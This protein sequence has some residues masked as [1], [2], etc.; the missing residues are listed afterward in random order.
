MIAA[1]LAMFLIALLGSRA[2]AVT[3]ATT[4][5]QWGSANQSRQSAYARLY[6]RE[7]RSVPGGGNSPA[8]V[9]DAINNG[10]LRAY[11]DDV[12]A[13]VSVLQAISGNF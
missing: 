12:S 8:S 13:T 10:C 1:L 6:L 9:L 7:H 4:C 5:S 2:G 3:D 11:S